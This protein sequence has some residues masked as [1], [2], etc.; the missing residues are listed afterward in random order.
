MNNNEYNP[1]LEQEEQIQEEV[2]ESTESTEEAEADQ[3]DWKAEAMK[4]KAIASRKA[5]Q[6]ESKTKVESQDQPKESGLS[7]EDIIVISKIADKEKIES[8]KEIAK[9]K[10][11]TMA[12]ASESTMYKLAEREIDQQ[13]SAE[14]AQ[15]GAS[16]GSGKRATEKT[17]T[18][19]GLS[20]DEHKE[21]F[22]KTVGK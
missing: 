14:K 13:R 20:R 22:Y 9:M 7:E 1:E 12:Q 10:G 17:F 19:P 3:V 2:D 15:L 21:M 4:W 8:L 18:T 5:K 6:A 16:R 11:L